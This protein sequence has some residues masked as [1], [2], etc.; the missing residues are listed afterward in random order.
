MRSGEPRQW[1]QSQGTDVVENA[2]RVKRNTQCLRAMGSTFHSQGME[3][4]GGLAG[5]R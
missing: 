3:W 4:R 2:H 1:E 5:H